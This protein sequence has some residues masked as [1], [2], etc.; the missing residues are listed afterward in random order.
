MR[1]ADQGDGDGVEEVVL[2]RAD[3]LALLAVIRKAV[4]WPLFSWV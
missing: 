2:S 4:A 1:R 3:A